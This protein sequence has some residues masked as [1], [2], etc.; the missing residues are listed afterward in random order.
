MSSDLTH[1]DTD[2]LNN[3]KKDIQN[4]N[5]KTHLEWSLQWIQR[6]TWI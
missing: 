1:D 4:L 6:E 5:P 2:N 3:Q